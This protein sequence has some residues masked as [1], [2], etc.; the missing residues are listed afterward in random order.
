MPPFLQFIIRRLLLIP[1][2]LFIITVIL[3]GGVMLTPAE[4]RAALYVPNTNRMMTEEQYRRMIDIIIRDHHLEEPLPIQY[5][6]WVKSLFEGGWGYSPSLRDEVLPSLLHRTPAT[7]ELTLYSLLLFVPLGLLSGAISGW[8][9]EK[10]FDTGFR[11][12]AFIS[13][14]IPSF[15][16][17]LIFIAIFY[18]QLDWFAPARVSNQTRFEI[19]DDSYRKP[20]GFITLDALVN[21]RYDIFEEALRH[22]AMPVMTLSL[23]HWAT[24]G[25]LTRSTIIETRKKEYIVSARARGVVERRVL[26]HHAFRN[27][28]AP[29]LTSMGLSAASLLTGVFV[30]EIIFGINGVSEVITKATSGIPDAPAAL[31]FAVYSVIMVLILMFVLDLVQAILDPRVRAEVF[32]L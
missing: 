26:W 10:W 23:Y 9:Q 27:A 7:A 15:I 1:V 29:A 4:A 2:S 28:L 22:L 25:R 13:T 8:R 17:A 32:G 12:I 6:F 3:Y 14:S 20:T 16:L 30:V 11:G 18:V 24:L 21:G 19:R 5:V 31:G